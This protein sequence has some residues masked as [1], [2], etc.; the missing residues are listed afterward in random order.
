MVDMNGDC[1]LREICSMVFLICQLITWSGV[2]FHRSR[3][4]GSHTVSFLKIYHYNTENWYCKVRQLL[5][6]ASGNSY[7]KVITNCDRYL[8]ESVSG[9]TKC[10]RYYNVWWMMDIYCKVCQVLQSVKVVAKWDVTPLRKH[11]VI[12]VWLSSLHVHDRVNISRFLR[13]SD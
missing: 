5:Q 2:L 12:D 1:S 9:I 8:L 3:K 7:Y 11:H 13:R 4:I 6:N 10:V